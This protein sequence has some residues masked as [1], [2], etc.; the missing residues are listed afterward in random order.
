MGHQRLD[1]RDQVLRR[2][3]RRLAAGRFVDHSSRRE[4]RPPRRKGGPRSVMG[5]QRRQCHRHERVLEV[6]GDRHS[7]GRLGRNVRQRRAAFSRSHRRFRLPRPLHDRFGLRAYRQRQPRRLRRPYPLRV[8]QHPALHRA[9]LQARFARHDRC[10]RPEHSERVRLLAESAQV[11]QNPGTVRSRST[12]KPERGRRSA[13]TRSSSRGRRSRGR[14]REYGCRS[15][16][17]RESN[18]YPGVP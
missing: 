11:H 18:P 8:R 7:L 12:S 1:A 16:P 9:D 10:A 3:Y 13:A 17:D 4:Q 15:A 14:C 6:D 2:R 5:G